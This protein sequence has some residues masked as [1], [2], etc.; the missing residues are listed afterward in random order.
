M[1]DSGKAPKSPKHS[2]PSNP[3]NREGAPNARNA[4][5]G[6]KPKQATRPAKEHEKEHDA[7]P[8]PQ[9]PVQTYIPH[10]PTV[11]LNAGR[12]KSLLK[13]HPWVFSGAVARTSGG[14]Q[15]G[16]TVAVR[17][18][19]GT[20]LAWAAYSPKSQIRARAWSFD[21][22]EAP[23]EAWLRARVRR[24]VNARNDLLPVDAGNARRLVHGESDGLPGLIAD[25]YGELLVVQCLSAGAERWREVL[26][27][28]LIAASGC[29][30]AW[31]RSDTDA[32]VLEGLG[33]RAGSLRGE[34]PGAP[35]EITEHGIRYRVDVVEGQKT[36]F[37]LDQRDN[38]LRVRGLSAGRAV[39]NCFAYTGGFTL[40]ALAGGAAS[41]VSVESSEPA[42]AAER[43]NL[44]LN[45]MDPSRLEQR[46]GNVFGLLRAL[47][48]EGARFGMIVLDP[49]KFAPT[50]K[51]AERAA[52]GYKDI[53]LHAMRLLEPGGWL[54]TFSCS[55]GIATELFQKIVAG[56]A[57]DAGVPLS[58]VGRLQAA[59]D[60][61]VSMDFPE[62]EYLKGLLL[63]RPR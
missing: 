15:L 31:E 38:R 52:R 45:G 3:S 40:S 48:A 12:D 35:V 24:A 4:S 17:A 29:T 53:N 13:R 25:Q 62:G 23:D 28:E 8:A 63:H 61:P 41:V 20:F 30:R 50:P 37:Y 21:E 49:P 58:I 54:A 1:N 43:A 16:D 27:D 39:L 5:K 34:V 7:A 19:D 46:Q 51:D 57:S 6:P 36:G 44:L 55:G 2:K 59:A 11:M 47:G 32:R 9:P 56:A 14:P 42:Q 26:V 18:A 10:G 33:P 60:H 22:A